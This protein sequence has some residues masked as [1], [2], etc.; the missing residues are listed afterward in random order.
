MYLFLGVYEGARLSDRKGYEKDVGIG[1]GNGSQPT[2]LFLTGRIPEI[3]R[4]IPHAQ[5]NGP[6]FV[7]NFLG[8]IFENG[9]SVLVIEVTFGIPRVETVD[10]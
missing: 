9:G 2:V 8:P 7:E 6:A 3:K 5:M 10:T 4:K 1:V